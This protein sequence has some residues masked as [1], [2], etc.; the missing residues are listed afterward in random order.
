MF[1][2]NILADG[3]SMDEIIDTQEP[4]AKVAERGFGNP[5]GILEKRGKMGYFVKQL[6]SPYGN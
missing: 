3:L 6:L 4:P 1:F 2:V 5:F